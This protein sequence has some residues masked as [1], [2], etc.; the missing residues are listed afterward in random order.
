MD[1][2]TCKFCSKSFKPKRKTQKFCDITCQK[3]QWAAKESIQRICCRDECSTIFTVPFQ[4]DLKKYCSSSCAAKVNNVSTPKRKLEGSCGI[5]N[6]PITSA[7]IYC[8]EHIPSSPYLKTVL[9]KVCKNERCG[10]IFKTITKHRLFCEDSCRTSWLQRLPSK[11]PTRSLVCPSCNGKKGKMAKHCNGCWIEGLRREKIQ[12]WLN[13]TWRG[14]TD[15]K[16]SD[17]IRLYLLEEAN[18]T[19]VRPGC[20]FNTMHPSDGKPVLEINHIDGNGENHSPSNLEVICPN[21]HSLTPSYRG[22]NVGKG[23]NT[24]YLRIRR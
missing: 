8:D 5:C 9:D 6:V 13:G 2:I 19:C 23:R 10:K 3:G 17:T 11:D 7:R 22:R 1:N 21:C 20:G 15:N 18:Y 14:G 16:L 24:Y 4:Y 12:S